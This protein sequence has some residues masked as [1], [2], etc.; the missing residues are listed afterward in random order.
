M[1]LAQ[2]NLIRLFDFYLAVVFLVSSSLRLRRYQSIL[3][4]VRAVPGRWPRLLFLVKD[5]RT[6]FLTWTTVLPALSAFTLSVT[7]MLACRLVLPHA[8]LS[9]ADLGVYWQAL[10]VIMILG[11]AMLGVDWY[12][13]FTFGKFDRKQM[14]KYFDQAEYWLRPWTAPVVR[15]FTLGYINPRKMVAVEVRKA[16]IESSRLINTTLWWMTLQLGLRV[17]FGLSLWLTYFLGPGSTANSWKMPGPVAGNAWY[18]I[19]TPAGV[20]EIS[21]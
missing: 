5:H 18:D 10:P 2:L 21:C 16:L 4:L 19:A 14:E 3:A 11:A 17:A 12:A 7:H 20:T 13:T 9:V 15:V 8:D 1:S 6:V